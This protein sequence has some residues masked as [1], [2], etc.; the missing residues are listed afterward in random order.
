MIPFLI[1]IWRF[2]KRGGRRG[3][4]VADGL[5]EAMRLRQER[6]KMINEELKRALAPDPR[7]PAKP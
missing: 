7:D 2:L 6:E 3:D 1:V 5:R 4:P